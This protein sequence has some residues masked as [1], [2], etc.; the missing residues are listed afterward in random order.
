[1]NKEK[2]SNIDTKDIV[3]EIY[4]NRYRIIIVSIVVSI[5][6][7]GVSLLIPNKFKSTASL[8]PNPNRGIG[9]DIFAENGGIQS[10]ASTFL[11]GKSNEAN[12]FYILL[13]SYNTKLAVVENF[14]LVEVYETTDS[15]TP[16]LSAIEI[17][18]ENLNF[19]SKEEGNFVIEVWDK[20]PVRAKEIND[21]L[22]EELSKRNNEIS[23]R[24]A[25][26][27]RS[28]MEG[29]YNET[30]ATLSNLTDSLE[31]FQSEFGVLEL[32]TQVENY[33]SVLA[34]LSVNKYTAEIKVDL[35]E[36]TLNKNNSTYKTAVAELN[37]IEEKLSAT[38]NDSSKETLELNFNEIPSISKK[39]FYLVENIKV[40]TEILK[41]IVPLVEQAK[42][43]QAKSIPVVSI[44]DSP[45]VPE[46]KDKPKRS[47]LVI[48]SFIS[49]IVIM[50]LYSLISLSVRKNRH[51]LNEIFE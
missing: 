21:F 27:Y 16:T 37:A 40:Q 38:Y 35:L 23:S 8:F 2:S 29:R 28:F 7:A 22:I 43:D 24:E 6:T 36:N 10:L 3:K 45:R 14:N 20:D 9:F 12:R 44:I 41:F 34:N 39:Y 48:L 1:M 25:S 51:I 30:L 26:Y 15:E 13:E 46:L 42:M 33:L 50:T 4:R 17:L 5:V 19:E 32:P 47:R 18:T 31:F 49:A 11:G